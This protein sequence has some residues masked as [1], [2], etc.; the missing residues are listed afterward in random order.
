MTQGLM[1]RVSK[2]RDSKTCHVCGVRERKAAAT[3]GELT[4]TCRSL[5]CTRTWL[6]R[7]K[8]KG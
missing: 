2:I 1:I 4:M 5:D 6:G 7:G 8:Q 3:D